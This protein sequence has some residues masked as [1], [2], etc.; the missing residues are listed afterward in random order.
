MTD[1]Q[2]SDAYIKELNWEHDFAD[3]L[4][5]LLAI[6]NQTPQWYSSENNKEQFCIIKPIDLLKIDIFKKINAELLKHQ[7]RISVAILRKIKPF[8]TT[9]IHTDWP[10]LYTALNIPLLN[11][12]S[13][14]T[15]WYN[16]DNDLEL[17]SLETV[18][19]KLPADSPLCLTTDRD[20]DR[21]LKFKIFEFTMSKPVLF[22]TSIP[23]NV[24]S[25]NNVERIILSV[26]FKK[27][28]VYEL[29][30]TDNAIFDKISIIR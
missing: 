9:G 11:P 4:P 19:L 1:Y 17:S 20:R 27:N 23:H 22:N 6:A 13:A 2:F 3:E 30:W 28:M 7:I 21:L 18:A 12:T 29:D 25:I 24:Q 10:G 8:D 14:V 5:A 15:S 16:F 26:Q